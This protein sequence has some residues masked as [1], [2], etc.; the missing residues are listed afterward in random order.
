[1]VASYGASNA[2]E[3]TPATLLGGGVTGVMTGGVQR[4]VREEKEEGTGSVRGL[5]GLA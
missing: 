2:G 3:V 1:V 4:S 5:A